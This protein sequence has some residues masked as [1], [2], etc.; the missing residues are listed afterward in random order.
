MLKYLL[1]TNIAIY[2][3]KRWPIEMLEIFN[4]H[5]GQLC[6]SSITLAKL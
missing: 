1:D 4:Q 6:V 3:I 5:S 2:V